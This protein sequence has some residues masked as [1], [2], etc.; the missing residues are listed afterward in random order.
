MKLLNF[1]S[2]AIDLVYPRQCQECGEMADCHE[3]SF[4]CDSCF[5]DVPRIEA[6]FCET[7]SM[8]FHGEVKTSAECPNCREMIIC[9]DKACSVMRFRGVIRNAI[10]SFKYSHQ[11]YWR[12][13]LQRWFIEGALHY[14]ELGDIDLILP[15]P[16]HPVRQRER[17][18]NQAAVLGQAL[19]RTLQKECLL[20]EIRR[21]RPTETQ[22]HL[23]RQERMNNLNGAFAVP[24]PQKIFGKKLLLVDDV[25]TTGSTVN[26]C[27]KILKEH[28]A[29]SVL[30]F[31]L[32]RG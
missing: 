20:K 32:A 31:T 19:S 14:P 1:V 5:K 3:F 29:T 22:T 26:E 4:L 12:K 25:L 2:S 18:F 27:A 30:V 15:V 23:D 6:P 21:I 7:C 8:P 9:F 28:G 24:K 10:H 13:V 11:M 16:L 17:G